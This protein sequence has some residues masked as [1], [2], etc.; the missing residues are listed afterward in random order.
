MLKRKHF[1][2]LGESFAEVIDE[3]GRSQQTINTSCDGL[4]LCRILSHYSKTLPLTVAYATTIGQDPYSQSLLKSFNA[5]GIDTQLVY[6]TP[7]LAPNIRFIAYH[8]QSKLL[9]HHYSKHST[10]FFY[11]AHLDQ[12]STALPNYHYLLYPASLL[13][14]LSTP[15][16]EMLLDLLQQ[17]FN[18]ETIII[19]YN[20][21]LSNQVTK[22][23]VY[24]RCLA[25]TDILLTSCDNEN[26]EP[27]KITINQFFQRQRKYNLSEALFIGDNRF[28]LASNRAVDDFTVPAA[29]KAITQ[30]VMYR[31][32][33]FAGYLAGR[34]KGLSPVLSARCGLRLGQ[35]LEADSL[36][37]LF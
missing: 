27:S 21:V 10:P 6:H 31:E 11:K 33:I 16:Q 26:L 32:A 30:Q 15:R 25:L 37:T 8:P 12:L 29:P 9:N 4:E 13:L 24:E 2:V 36:P 20:N 28:W 17:A 23:S 22:N 3:P 34:L 19:L 5:Q 18:N 14:S 1:L 7:D 35:R